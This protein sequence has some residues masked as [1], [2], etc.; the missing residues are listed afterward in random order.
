M[1]AK[2]VTD[3]FTE[4]PGWLSIPRLAGIPAQG[5]PDRERCKQVVKPAEKAEVRK[6]VDSWFAA[7]LVREANDISEAQHRRRMIEKSHNQTS[8]PFPIAKIEAEIRAMDGDLFTQAVETQR[9]ANRKACKIAVSILERLAESFDEELCAAALEAEAR[10]NKMGV[11]LFTDQMIAGHLV[12]KYELHSDTVLTALQ[13]RRQFAKLVAEKL[14]K[15]PDDA[16]IGEAR[17]LCTDD[18]CEFAWN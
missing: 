11:A 12:R 18:V 10:L 16:G 1:P 2:P 9:E 15:W 5:F 14:T 3:F 17:W 4:G 8:A 13:C 7:K 6:L